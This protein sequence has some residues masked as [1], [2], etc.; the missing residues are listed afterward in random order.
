MYIIHHIVPILHQLIE[1][2]YSIRGL[3]GSLLTFFFYTGIILGYA[4]VGSLDYYTVPLV[5]V[6][7]P[8]CFFC[9]FFWVPNT[10]QFLLKQNRPEVIRIY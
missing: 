2:L 9:L 4:V 5:I 1:S 7:L 6:A 10:P 8:T 3:F